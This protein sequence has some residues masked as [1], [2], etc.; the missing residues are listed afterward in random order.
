MTTLRL[1]LPERLERQ[2]R[3]V[4]KAKLTGN[5][6]NT[7]RALEFYRGMKHVLEE[8]REREQRIKKINEQLKLQREENAK[9]ELLERDFL[10]WERADAEITPSGW[11]EDL[12]WCEDERLAHFLGWNPEQLPIGRVKTWLGSSRPR[13]RIEYPWDWPANWN[14]RNLGRKPRKRWS[15]PR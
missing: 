3:F 1:N 6:E 10:G 7:A 13:T 2:L 5:E 12:C 9:R 14:K 8:E 15:R 4:F 11:L